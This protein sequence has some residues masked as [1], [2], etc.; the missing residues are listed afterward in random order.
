MNYVTSQDLL[1]ESQLRNTDVFDS[2]LTTCY[3]R[4]CFKCSVRLTLNEYRKWISDQYRTVHV[5]VF[6]IVCLVL[7]QTLSQQ[8]AMI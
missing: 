6:I 7:T 5:L 3:S 1:E 8:A 2:I 4:L